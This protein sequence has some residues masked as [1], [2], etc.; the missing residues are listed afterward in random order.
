MPA[1]NQ[2]RKKMKDL[3]NS[4]PSYKIHKIQVKKF[5]VE[6]VSNLWKPQNKAAHLKSQ[7][8]IK[9]R[10]AHCEIC[11]FS[12]RDIEKHKEQKKNMKNVPKRINLIECF[13][14]FVIFIT[15]EKR[16]MSMRNQKHI[17]GEEINLKKTQ[18]RNKKNNYSFRWFAKRISKRNNINPT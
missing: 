1:K 12:L 10:K 3:K 17:L 13:V 4:K 2:I 16:L 18:I 9:K 5:Y 8:S 6:L 11:I 7:E 15:K 14:K